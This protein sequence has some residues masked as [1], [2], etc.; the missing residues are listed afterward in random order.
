MCKFQVINH[1]SFGCVV[2]C[3]CCQHLHL[4]FGNVL[5]VFSVDEFKH[6]T[7]HIE[8]VFEKNYSEMIL[9]GEKIYLNTD[10]EKFVITLN[11]DELMELN[12]LLTE[13]RIMLQVHQ[14]LNTE[15]ISD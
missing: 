9:T 15:N 10:S 12:K 7:N 2:K 3:S 13:A 6:F 1:N 14:I 4:G 5:T 8:R 11:P